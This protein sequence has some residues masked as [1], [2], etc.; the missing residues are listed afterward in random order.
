MRR[1]SR[2]LREVLSECAGAVVGIVALCSLSVSVATEGSATVAMLVA[3]L[4]VDG[5]RVRPIP[6]TNDP[7]QASGRTD[8]GRGPIESAPSNG[9][10]RIR[11]IHRPP[12]RP[13]WG[14][15]S[16]PHAWFAATGQSGSIP[17]Q[18]CPT[19]SAGIPRHVEETGRR[20]VIFLRFL[21]VV[22]TCRSP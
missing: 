3:K 2:F 6:D 8:C 1:R 10:R 20:L 14:P 16:H 11:V 9:G 13:L 12:P 22:N 5:R 17:I 4:P 15:S 7:K 19:A 18:H 21:M